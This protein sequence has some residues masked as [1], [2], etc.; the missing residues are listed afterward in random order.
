MGVESRSGLTPR[1]KTVP[2]N[3]MGEGIQKMGLVPNGDVETIVGGAPSGWTAAGV[4]S[5]VSLISGGGYASTNNYYARVTVPSAGAF[6]AASS[7]F[8]VT[9]GSRLFANAYLRMSG[10]KNAQVQIKEYTSSWGFI[11]TQAGPAY[12]TPYWY[13][14]S[15]QN[16]VGPWDITLSSKTAIVQLVITGTATAANALLDFDTVSVGTRP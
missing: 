5:G 2:G 4:M 1:I 11:Q 15:Y 3:V 16:Q 10:V 13:L 8:S 14:A 9:P 6:W 12:N 7:G